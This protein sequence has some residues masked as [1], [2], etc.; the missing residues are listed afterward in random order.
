MN[1]KRNYVVIVNRKGEEIDKGEKL[2]VHQEGKLHR[3]FS[4]FIF[5]KNGELLLQRRARGKYHSAGLWSNTCCSHPRPGFNI[6]EEAERRLKEEMGI[7]TGLR[8]VFSFIY[9][10]RVGELIEYEFDHIFFGRFDGKPKIDKKEVEDWMWISLDELEK[11]IKKNPKKYT[12]WFKKIIKR[13][14]F[15][16]KTILK[17]C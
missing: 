7:K 13:N 6:K 15:Q 5:N 1:I 14:G 3:A 2:K 16:F 12:F 9:R 17:T 10:A 4:I 8:E 11:D